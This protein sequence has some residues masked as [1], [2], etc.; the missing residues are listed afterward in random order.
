MILS[1]QFTDIPIAIK[2][3]KKDAGAN[4]ILNKEEINY[5]KSIN[6]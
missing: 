4:I 6:R 1:E 3:F 5:K 2:E